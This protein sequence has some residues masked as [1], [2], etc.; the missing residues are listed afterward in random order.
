MLIPSSITPM[1]KGREQ[2][3]PG[4][5]ALAGASQS[6]SNP[7]RRHAPSAPM[8]YDSGEEAKPQEAQTSKTYDLLHTLSLAP[9]AASIAPKRFRRIDPM[10]VSKAGIHGLGTTTRT[11][12]CC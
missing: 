3:D 12:K 5:N 4:G 11:G 10:S 1:I 8:Q 7:N 9:A 2:K 6:H